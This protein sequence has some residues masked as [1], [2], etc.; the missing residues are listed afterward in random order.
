MVKVTHCNEVV[1]HNREE[2][3]LI[4]VICFQIFSVVPHEMYST[5]QIGRCNRGESIE[6][7]FCLPSNSLQ[8]SSI[9][10]FTSTKSLFDD[11]IV[12]TLTESRCQVSVR[13]LWQ[14]SYCRTTGYASQCFKHITLLSLTSVSGHD[15]IPATDT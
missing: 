12:I 15:I 4:Q 2:N 5:T 7:A 3:L 9:N 13:R 6:M 11:V 8:T 1:G 14:V 10:T